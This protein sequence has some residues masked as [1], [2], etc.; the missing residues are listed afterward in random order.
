MTEATVA[1][2][3]L[4][5]GSAVIRFIRA[6][7][8]IVVIVPV[9]AARASGA[10]W[11]AALGGAAVAALL[12]GLFVWLGWRRFR[13]GVGPA[14]IVIEQGVFNRTRRS[15]P[16]DRV[17]DV[18][19]ERGPLHRL[20]GL[21]RVRIE[22]GAGGKDEGVLD[23]VSLGEA[24]RLRA[25][26]RGGQVDVHAEPVRPVS[27]RS[28]IFV[29]DLPRV[30]LFGLFNFS[31]VYIAGI[32]AVLNFFDDWLPFGRADLKRYA[33]EAVHRVEEGAV[34]PML[35]LIVALIAVLLGVAAGIARTLAREYGY[36]VS[37]EPAGFRRE[38]GLFTRSEAVIPRRRVQ[39]ALV[40]TGP[41]RRLGGWFALSFQT[42]GEGEKNDGGRQAVA[43]FARIAEVT[44]IVADARPLRLPD[45]ALLRPVSRKHVLRALLPWLLLPMLAV[46]IGGFFFPPVWFGLIAVAGQ[47]MIMLLERRR[48]RYAF[49]GD[50]LFVQRG[51]WRQ[52]LWLV[53]VGSVQTLSLERSPLQRLLGLATV[54]VDTAGAAV[55]ATPNICD[56]RHGDA[57]VLRDTLGRVVTGERS[58]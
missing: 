51:W 52:R 16:L 43:P 20:F 5:P 33:G 27:G 57:V 42:L 3:R 1:D 2:R 18:D 54:A 6:L 58:V 36:R 14:G 47:A 23:S 38:R 29:M 4:H 50:M 34:T 48:H 13:Y 56:L 39:L 22:T 55:L 40:E 11:S 35:L 44:A 37:A 31:L 7:P 9:I 32:Y 10:G 15:I 17:Q 26:V 19:V 21:A 12:T 53:P 49:D 24:D 25:A 45:P 30:L 41:F 8:Q 28:A 46:A